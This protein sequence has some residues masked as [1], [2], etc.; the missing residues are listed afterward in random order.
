MLLIMGTGR[1]QGRLLLAPVVGAVGRLEQRAVLRLSGVIHLRALTG[2]V[3]CRLALMGVVLEVVEVPPGSRG[4]WGSGLQ[5]RHC[6]SGVGELLVL[7]GVLYRDGV[8]YVLRMLLARVPAGLLWV[9][10]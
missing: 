10:I 4:R 3:R 1:P 2:E 7:V 5:R 8:R 6:R 9:E